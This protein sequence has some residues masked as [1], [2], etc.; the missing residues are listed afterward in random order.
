MEK[1]NSFSASKHDT[2]LFS[3]IDQHY[4][5]TKYLKKKKCKHSG[6]IETKIIAKLCYDVAR[7]E[8]LP[9]CG[10]K[11]SGTLY[12]AKVISFLGRISN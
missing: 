2:L 5:I 4:Q 8:D 6:I 3:I 11:K 1:T 7:E 9:H 10:Y 12:S